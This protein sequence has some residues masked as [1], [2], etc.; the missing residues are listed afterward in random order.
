[1]ANKKTKNHW[2]KFWKLKLPVNEAMSKQNVGSHPL[3]GHKCPKFTFGPNH[4]W[5]IIR[6]HTTLFFST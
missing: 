4:C 5:G 2:I 1:M 3:L 6:V